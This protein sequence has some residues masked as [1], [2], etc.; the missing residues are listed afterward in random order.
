MYDTSDSKDFPTHFSILFEFHQADQAIKT[1]SERLEA[2]KSRSISVGELI[3][4]YIETYSITDEYWISENEL[5]VRDAKDTDI[6]SS[7]RTIWARGDTPVVDVHPLTLSHF[8]ARIKRE[9]STAD[10][11]EQQESAANTSSSQD[12]AADSQ[13]TATDSQKAVELWRQKSSDELKKE[14]WDQ[15]AEPRD[16]RHDDEDYRKELAVSALIA[17]DER[18]KSWIRLEYEKASQIDESGDSQ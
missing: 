11:Q 8:K 6:M 9:Y 4:Q 15:K 2:E 12:A 3:E 16:N 10:E 18:S 5:A 13:T 1:F 7:L 17:M 14:V